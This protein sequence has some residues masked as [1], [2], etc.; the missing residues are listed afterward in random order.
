MVLVISIPSAGSS[1]QAERTN[2]SQRSRLP[3]AS[4]TRNRGHETLVAPL[5]VSL[6]AG[7]PARSNSQAR[8]RSHKFLVDAGQ[9]L[10]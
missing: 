4:A 10:E 6:H 2:G 3:W 5:A 9:L 7:P 8:A 1:T